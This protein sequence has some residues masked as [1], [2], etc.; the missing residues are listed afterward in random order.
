MKL[1]LLI[2]EVSTG[3]EAQ[4]REI[5]LMLADLMDCQPLELPLMKDVNLDQAFQARFEEY[6]S[7]LDA[8][9]PVQYILGKAWFYGLEF[10]VNPAVLIPRPETEGLVELA[11]EMATS[12]SRVLDIGTGSGAIA[13]ALKKQ[14]PDLS[15]FATDI[16]DAALAV[17]KGNARRHGC[18][19]EFECADLFPSS[20]K[21][22]D[23]VLSNPPYISK[24][25][26][27]DLDSLIRDH[28]PWE[29]LQAG[30]DGLIYY[31]RILQEAKV[32][33][34]GHTTFLFEHGDMQRQGIV[35]LASELGYEC[36]LAKDDLAGRNR[37]LGFHLRCAKEE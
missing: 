3:R 7:R 2:K 22:F 36:I 21:D 33:F 13:I 18:V 25:E 27:T 19:I 23:L 34:P 29:A 37:Y 30:Q 32:P 35:D 5:A 8:N 26:F 11:L 24:A 12:G 16:S 4:A 1:G 14:R 15:V 17:A 20:Q 10:T 28:E 9:E 6:L 31:Q